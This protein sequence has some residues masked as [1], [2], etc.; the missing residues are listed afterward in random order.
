MFSLLTFANVVEGT[1][2]FCLVSKS[3]LT[4]LQPHGAPLSMGFSRQE[5]W[6]EL[7]FPFLEGLLNP[8]ME[9]ISA[10][11]ADSFPLSHQEDC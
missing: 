11:Q 1:Y 2:C 10:L 7:P 9:P 4:L 8:E 5:C 6:S 3:C